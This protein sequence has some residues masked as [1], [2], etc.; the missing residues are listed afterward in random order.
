VSDAIAAM[1][2]RRVAER[3]I[4]RELTQEQLAEAAGISRQMVSL[5]ER[6]V[7]TPGWLTAYALAIALRCEVFDLLPTLREVKKLSV[8]P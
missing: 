6:G 3:R 1:I 4:E 2:G 5:I 7:K 8:A